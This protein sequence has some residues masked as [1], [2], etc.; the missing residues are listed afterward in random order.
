MSDNRR[1]KLFGELT[2]QA[3]DPQSRIPGDLLRDSLVIDRLH[4]VSQLAF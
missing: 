1:L 2:L 3:G 4:G